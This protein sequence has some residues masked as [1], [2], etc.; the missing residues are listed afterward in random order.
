MRRFGGIDDFLALIESIRTAIPL[1]GI[2]SNVIVGFPGETERDL[3]VLEEFLMSARLDAVGVFGYS[4][5]DGT[6]AATLESLPEVDV[7]RRVARVSDLVDDLVAGRAEE[8][9]G[10]RVDVLVVEPG[11]GIAGHQGPEDGRTHVAS[12]IPIG[13]MVVATVVGTHGVDMVAEVS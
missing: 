7:R 6:E 11:E 13:S 2:R 1:A 12:D 8:R 9:I 3:E 5:E 10:E 4:P